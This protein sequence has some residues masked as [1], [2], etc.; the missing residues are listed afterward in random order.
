MKTSIIYESIK[1]NDNTYIIKFQDNE[2]I[3]PGQF[4]M[5][6]VPGINEIPL[7]FSGLGDLK[8]I[9]IKIYGKASEHIAHLKKGDTIFFRGPYGKPFENVAGK[10]LLIGAGTGIAPLVPLINKNAYGV[11]SGKTGEDI[12]FQDRFEKKSIVTDDGSYG[13]KGY[14]VDALKDI[15]LS[16]FDMIYACGPEI[17]LKSVMDYIINING[18]AQFSLERPMKCGIG[19][20]DSCSIN[21]YQVCTDGPVFSLNQLMEMPEFGNTRLSYSGKRIKI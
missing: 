19:I 4:I 9:T 11:L 21:G 2:N 1:L 18:K 15:D 17:M 20:C 3:G 12:I 13:K 16:E 8:E 14:A 7:S 5:V 10:K 6:W